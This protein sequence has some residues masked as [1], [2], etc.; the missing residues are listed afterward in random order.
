MPVAIKTPFTL[1][2]VVSKYVSSRRAR[3]QAQ[4]QAQ[5]TTSVQQVRRWMHM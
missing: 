3:V 4:K 1:G 5:G 2:G